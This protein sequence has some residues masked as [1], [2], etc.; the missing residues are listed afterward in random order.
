MSRK[1]NGRDIQRKGVKKKSV[2]RY[3]RRALVIDKEE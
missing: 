1:K 2:V 3:M